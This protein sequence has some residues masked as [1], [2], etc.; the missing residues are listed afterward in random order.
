MLIYESMV[1]PILPFRSVGVSMNTHGNN[2]SFSTGLFRKSIDK[3]RIGDE[4]F[5]A[6]G[7]LTYA[8]QTKEFPNR[9]H[10]GLSL[11][12]RLSDT[13]NETVRYSGKPGSAISKIT[14][15][16]TRRTAIDAFGNKINL[17]Y[18]T[19]SRILLTKPFH[20]I[21]SI[22]ILYKNFQF[23]QVPGIVYIETF[24]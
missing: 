12:R 4:R 5:S 6:N 7:Q 20:G 19:S 15:V 3:T 11:S 22:I 17:L 1:S 2:R 8:F 9:L 18:Y 10:F 23:I 14:T 13:G 24:R 21:R 16:D